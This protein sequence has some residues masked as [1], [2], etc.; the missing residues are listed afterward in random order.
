MD[1]VAVEA[2]ALALAWAA[3]LTVRPW[4]M[5]RSQGGKVR[6]ATP[7]LACLTVLPWL[8]A[9]PGL[10][11]LPFPLH[12]SAAP[13]VTL[14]VGW[15]LAIPLVTLAGFS[16]IVTTDASFAQALSLTVWI[17]VLPATVVLALGHVVR[18]LLGPHPVAYML[19]RAF[20]VPMLALGGCAFAAAA[21]GHT[22]TGAPAALERVAIVLL[23]MGEASW[24]CALVS[25]LVAWRPQWLATWSDTLYLGRRTMRIRPHR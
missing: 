15:P 1:P 23:A 21:M 6:L 24:T 13:L 8:W 18:K 22:L 4:R 10:A 9:W 5:L 14:L 17:G 19:G 7:F 3:A 20:F 25:L 16:T 11:S 12:W 2:I